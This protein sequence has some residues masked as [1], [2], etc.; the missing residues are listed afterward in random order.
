[1][2]A[3]AKPNQTE[4][5]PV[6]P[7]ETDSPSGR[8]VT[9]GTLGF[10]PELESFRGIGALMVAS[11]HVVYSFTGEKLTLWSDPRSWESPVWGSLLWVLKALSNGIGALNVFFVL[12]GFV[13]ASSIARGPQGPGPAGRHFFVGRAFRL[14]PAIISTVLLFCIIFWLT[15]AALADNHPELYRPGNILR[16]MLLIDWNIDGVMWS[17]Q[18]EALAIP[19]IFVATIGQQRWGGKFTLLLAG[20]LLA[21][22]MSRPYRHLVGHGAFLTYFYAFVFGVGTHLIGPALVRRIGRTRLTLFVAALLLLF[23][24]PRVAL[25]FMSRWARLSECV[26]AVGLIAI[27]AYGPVT[28]LKKVLNWRLFRFYGRIS[29]SFYLLHPL[30]FLVI[31]KMPGPLSRLLDAGV[32]AVVLSI[33]LTVLSVAAITPPAWLSWRFIE[34]PGIAAGRRLSPERRNASP[35]VGPRGDVRR[36]AGLV[37]PR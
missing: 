18:V 14:Y 37:S 16:N 13:L 1:M 36:D 34:L 4:H 31:W 32:P 3:S 30:T 33:S 35:Y 19:L 25:G 11:I 27:V 7:T 12:S 29:Y 9:A 5:T 28:A 23:F 22:S 20:L 21:L 24:V 10:V 2:F 6:A 17:L 15:G 8:R 26:A